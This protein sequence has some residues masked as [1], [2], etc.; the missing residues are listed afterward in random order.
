MTLHRVEKSKLTISLS[1]LFLLLLAL[2]VLGGLYLFQRVNFLTLI[3]ANSTL[4]PYA[5]F[6]F[7]KTFRLVGNDMACMLMIYVFFRERKYLQVSFYFFLLELLVI[8]PLYFWIK[9]SIEGD[10]E[11]S[12]PLLSQ[13]HRI[14]VNPI[15][16]ILLMIAFWYQRIQANKTDKKV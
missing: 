6:V 4:H 14:I 2:A 3:S 12:S 1:D 5:Y 13:V 16:M 15:L 11:I 10:S 7:N 9:L 8:L